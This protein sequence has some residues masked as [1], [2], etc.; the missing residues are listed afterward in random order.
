MFLKRLEFLGFKS[1]ADKTVIEFNDGITALLGPNGC[2][3]SNVVDGVKWVLGEQSTK[4][5]RAEKMEDVIFN[6]TE[7][8][9]ALNIAEVT[10]VIENETGILDLDM[11]EVSIKRRLYRTGE[12]EY[13]I[14]NTP[15]RL[16][17]LRE[18]FF[19]TGV[20]KSAYSIMEQGRIDQIISTKPEERRY[21]FE[22]AAGIT[23][24]K[25]RGHEAELKLKKTDE[26]IVQV[27][28]ILVEVKRS[29]ETLK[30]QM[31][32]TLLYRK[33][34]DDIFNFEL[35][36]RL[37]QLNRSIEQK[38]KKEETHK[39]RIES[40]EKKKIKLEELTKTLAANLD[41][42]NG[43]QEE[44]IENQKRLYG[45]GLE[46]ENNQNQERM[47]QERKQELEAVITSIQAKEASIKERIRLVENENETKNQELEKFEIEVKEIEANI[48]SFEKHIINC[49]NRI[50]DNESKSEKLKENI[51]KS[52][53]KRDDFQSNLREITDN[54]VSELDKNL[55]RIGYSHK[56]KLESEEKINSMIE[57]LKI[58]VDGRIKRLSDQESLGV[59]SISKDFV[60]SWITQMGEMK[61]GIIKL[62]DELGAFM[63][64]FPD[65]VDDF[66]A[67]EGIIAKKREFDELIRKEIELIQN[68]RKQIENLQNEKEEL[69]KKIDEYKSTLEELRVNR[70][71]KIA[72]QGAIKDSI[73]SIKKEL[74]DQG[75]LLQENNEAKAIQQKKIDEIDSQ[76]KLKIEKRRELEI[77]EEEL[78]VSLDK[79]KKGITNQNSLL[80]GEEHKLKEKQEELNKIDISLETL[81]V[82]IKYLEDEMV[83][84]SDDFRENFSC[85]LNDYKERAE[86][87]KTSS[88]EIKG[89]LSDKKQ[90]L[91]KI[92]QVNLMA[93]EEFSEVKERY[94]F[95]VSQLDDLS[96]AKENLLEVTT[97]IKK[98]S[99]ELFLKSFNE[100]KKH[101]HQMF[102]RLFGGGRA[103]LKLLDP[104]NILES[105]IEIYAQPP[106][107]KLENIALL[108][109]G[110]K[111]M[112]GVGLLF[113]TYLVKPSPFCILDEI[114]AALDDANIQRFVNVLIDFGEMSQ[115]IVITHNKKTVTGAKTL[116]GVT[117][118]DSG[119]STVISMKLN[120][121]DE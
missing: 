92:G 36:L 48:E 90:E 91:R 75:K 35:D 49:E 110:E 12:S 33:I 107:K 117:M 101:F 11:A 60:S 64:L 39:K 1:F 53:I 34:K 88:Q 41:S 112:T 114:D 72:K 100:I 57:A 103:E 45:L 28:N 89:K 18:I 97:E 52:E 8:R 120:Q 31:D 16:K 74:E 42:V 5:M 69:T 96:K 118:Q 95:L 10:L 76:I 50:K 99:E 79:L 24:Y 22:E 40:R 2:G 59:D 77:L 113:A 83:K 4:N 61:D 85:E 115:F 111:S 65:F 9:K 56:G 46:K 80:E 62:E 19:D 67:P 54:I 47:F 21:I 81:H 15:A 108:S 119:V 87:L 66:M 55:H 6:G 105:G 27:N 30:K 93:P 106:G 43:M 20:G 23:K 104:E 109:G 26:N 73:L 7:D 63:K 32:K 51:K 44:L 14:N 68:S 25:V 86:K 82:E 71:Q 98:E 116:L 29:Y 37:I 70:V 121:E 78:Q 58:Q 102:R 38:T 17:E 13:F 3:K 94:D 84:I